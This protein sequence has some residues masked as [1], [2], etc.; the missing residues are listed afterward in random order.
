MQ[1]Y[2][3]QVFFFLIA[4]GGGDACENEGGRRRQRKP[5]DSNMS[6]TPQNGWLSSA[7]I[8][9]LPLRKGPDIPST[10]LLSWFSA[11]SL[12]GPKPRCWQVRLYRGPRGDSPTKLTQVVGRNQFLAGCHLETT[13]SS[14]RLSLVLE[15]WSLCLRDNSTVYNLEHPHTEYTEYNSAV[16]VGQAYTWNC[17]LKSSSCGCGIINGL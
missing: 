7:Q 3:S 11:E 12:P 5:S 2:F 8:K 9:N 4:R 17:I 6:Q 15:H 13:L 14:W 10:V 16:Q 1:P